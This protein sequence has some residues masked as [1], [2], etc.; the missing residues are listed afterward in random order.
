MSTFQWNHTS[1]CD[2]NYTKR[3]DFIP[4]HTAALLNKDMFSPNHESETEKNL[5]IRTNI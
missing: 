1:N 5:K 2:K 4:V 3:E